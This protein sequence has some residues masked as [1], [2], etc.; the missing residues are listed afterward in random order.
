M[1][2]SLQK[3]YIVLLD[4]QTLFLLL[5]L[6]LKSML[7]LVVLWMLVQDSGFQKIQTETKIKKKKKKKKKNFS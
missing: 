1:M 3:F 5:V 2:H 4:T 7:L 6:H